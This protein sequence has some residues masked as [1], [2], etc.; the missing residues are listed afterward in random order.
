MVRFTRKL[1][2]FMLNHDEICIAALTFPPCNTSGDY[3]AKVDSFP[4][5]GYAIA[6][7]YYDQLSQ[8]ADMIAPCGLAWQVSRGVTTIPT[9]CKNSI[10]KEYTTPS[11]F[12]SAANLSLPLKVAG[13]PSELSQFELYRILSKHPKPHG[14]NFDKHPNMAGQYLNALVFFATLFGES[15]IGASGPLHTGKAPD[16]P[17]APEILSG[18]QKIAHSVVLDHAAAW[19]VTPA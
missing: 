16:L 8:G 10:D 18:L 12:N 9:D 5:M 1:M 2:S 3:Q 19:H 15:P 13:V 14:G 4:C 6:R 17:L 7:G 11:P